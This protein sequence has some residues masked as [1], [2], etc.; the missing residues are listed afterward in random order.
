VG[1]VPLGFLLGWLLLLL[2]VQGEWAAAL[3]LPLYYLADA[4]ITL[5]HRALCGG[6]IWQAHRQHFYQRAVQSGLGHADVVRH[7]SMVNFM[8]VVLAM[9]ASRGYMWA[10]LAAAFICVGWLLFFLSG[11]HAG[12][13]D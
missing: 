1:S 6:K 8:L 12:R 4:T 3:I 13:Q 9:T 7:I 5:C 11:D 2:A 10:S